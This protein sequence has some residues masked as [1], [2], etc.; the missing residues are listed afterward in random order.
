MPDKPDKDAAVAGEKDGYSGVWGG[1]ASIGHPFLFA[2]FPI[3]SA[4]S[5]NAG[6]VRFCE[7]LL[8]LA[9]GQ[10]LAGILLVLCRPLLKSWSKAAVIASVFVVFFFSY[11]HVRTE[12]FRPSFMSN[13]NEEYVYGGWCVLMAA[14]LF[15]A[16]WVRA[17]SA[18]IGKAAMCAGLAVNIVCIAGIVAS[19]APLWLSHRSSPEPELKAKAP[20]AKA[21]NLPRR[22]IYQLMIERYA[23]VDVLK[24]HYGF[25]NTEFL[26][27]LRSRGFFIA[28]KCLA[29]YGMTPEGVA[30]PFNMDYLDEL[31]KRVG[32]DCQNLL[33]LLAMLRNH[34]LLR[35]L[36]S[37]G[38]TYIH[39]GSSWEHLSR[40]EYADININYYP[41][42][43]FWSMIF[44]STM[45][46][47]PIGKKLHCRLSVR[48]ADKDWAKW[49]RENRLFDKMEK[50]PEI[51]G[52]TFAFAHVT[53][54]HNPFIFDRD[55]KF[56]PSSK[57]RGGLT[58]E[59]AYVEAMRYQNKRLKQL[60]DKLLAAPGPK[61]IIILQADE[62]PY[63]LRYAK[64]KDHFD[65]AKATDDELIQKMA[66]LNALYLPGM[67]YGDLP[68]T[69]SPVNTFR[70][71]L[72][73][74]FGMDLP[75]LPDRS[76]I[77]RHTYERA[78]NVVDVTS[79]LRQIAKRMHQ[80]PQ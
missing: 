14:G 56:V 44:K 5:H 49:L 8:P 60:V 11:G 21:Q 50:L 39:F 19:K 28:P 38:Y 16:W 27:Y 69:L 76:Y 32:P 30:A 25:D 40:N 46:Y 53:I 67:D 75:L 45:L 35:F 78:Y 55:G 22:D 18:A 36:K 73:H 77:F 33:P 62:G 41:V 26:A 65:W 31:I 10:A 61:P 1:L 47:W 66:I 52:P 59:R 64:D 72:S 70:L 63:P 51:P 57:K 58:D 48:L 43:E 3:L 24:N 23:R 12:V 13:V 7:V 71:V 37:R 80:A 9:L 74:Y 17:S 68:P 79:R 29:N 4:Y 6:Q 42:R 15:L 34:R 54:T 20:G 2:A